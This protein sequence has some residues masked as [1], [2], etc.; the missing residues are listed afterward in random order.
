MH[1]LEFIKDFV[2]VKVRGVA[3]G[4][5]DAAAVH[6]VCAVPAALTMPQTFVALQC[7]F[8]NTFQGQLDKK[9][10]K[11]TCVVCNAKQSFR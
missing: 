7:A 10:K 9:A 6:V 5:A 4:S 1:Q 2:R 11:F 3:L 8:C